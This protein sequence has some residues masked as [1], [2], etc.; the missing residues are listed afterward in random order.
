LAL[1][2]SY[3]GRTYPP[4][5]VYEVGRQKILEFADAIGDPNPVYRDPA[6]AQAYGHRDVM[7]PPTFPIIITWPA[8]LLIIEDPKFGLDF[9]RLLHA[10]QRFV[11]T[12]PIFA[13]DQLTATV[14]IE[15]VS[16]RGGMGFLSTRTDLATVDGEHVVTGYSKLVIT[17]EAAE[18]PEGEAR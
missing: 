13:D 2:E 17:P 14:T 6:A 5:S 12:R 9:A 16:T 10:E 3:A 7:A 1:D 4:Q 18:T 11:Y 15:S 8:A